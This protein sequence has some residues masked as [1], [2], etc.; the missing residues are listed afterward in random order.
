[1]PYI[2]QELGKGG[3]ENMNCTFDRSR[4]TGY[5]A[6]EMK[7]VTH[8]NIRTGEWERENTKNS[9]CPGMGASIH[10]K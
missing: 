7:H 6:F 5:F 4:K 9:I 10:A 2:V 8:R 1:M 3:K